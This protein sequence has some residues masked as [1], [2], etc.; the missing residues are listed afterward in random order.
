MHSRTLL[1][2]TNKIKHLLLQK[3]RSRQIVIAD[4]TC[5]E[6][7]R[8]PAV[9][10]AQ[11]CSLCDEMVAFAG[12]NRTSLS[13]RISLGELQAHFGAPPRQPCEVWMTWHLISARWEIGPG[14]NATSA[15]PKDCT[16]RS[17]LAPQSGCNRVP[18]GH[19]PL[20]HDHDS[21]VRRLTSRR[22]DLLK[23]PAEAL[24]PQP[25]GAGWR[26]R[27]LGSEVIRCDWPRRS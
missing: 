5:E 7:T 27:K 23:Q 9:T 11:Q 3:D 18:P 10:P 25:P 15:P 14:E 13:A 21:N 17:R 2:P 22:P 6:V 4:Q 16:S 24:R 1:P 12:T 20:A 19:R 8:A 26:E